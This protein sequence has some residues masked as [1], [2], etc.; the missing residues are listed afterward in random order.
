M[1]GAII[2]IQSTQNW[3]RWKIAFMAI[4]RAK[5]WNVTIIGIN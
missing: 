2:H 1:I 3:H 4:G 5:L